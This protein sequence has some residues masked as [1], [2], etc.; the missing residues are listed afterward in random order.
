MHNLP[1]ILKDS[2]HNPSLP[3]TFILYLTFEFQLLPVNFRE[4]HIII[5]DFNIP[6]NV[7]TSASDTLKD[8]VNVSNLTLHNAYP[9]REA[10]NTLDLII[11]QHKNIYK[12]NTTLS[13]HIHNDHSF[14]ITIQYS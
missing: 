8:L 14:P 2:Q 7:K 11:S 1:T 9:T 4:N 6:T 13:S 12:N 5:G 3:A 10:G